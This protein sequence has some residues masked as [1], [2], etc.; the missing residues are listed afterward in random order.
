MSNYYIYK[1]I[2]GYDTYHN[3]PIVYYAVMKEKNGIS[4][5]VGNWYILEKYALKLLE[6]LQA[7][8]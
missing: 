2:Q 4:Q 8:E 1:D 6:K 7:T 3:R 5:Q